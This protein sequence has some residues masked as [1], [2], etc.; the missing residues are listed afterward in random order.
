MAERTRRLS[1]RAKHDQVVYVTI[2]L[3]AML[4]TDN[5][6]MILIEGVDRAGKSTLTKALKNT[7][8]WDSLTLTHRAGNQFDRYLRAYSF[9]QQCVVE[10]GHLS[11]LIYSQILR[12]ASP[13]SE[14]ELAE[15]ESW[16]Q[17]S[18]VVW[19]C[20]EWELCK[21]RYESDPLPPVI[22]P[23]QLRESWENYNE[24]FFK[25]TYPNLYV[26]HSDVWEEIDSCCQ[27]VSARAEE[28]GW[29]SSAS[30]HIEQ[31]ENQGE[32]NKK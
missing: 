31:T 7:L 9:A 24:Y 3:L 22:S 17:P 28:L 26:Y 20:P 19:A 10:R 12:G 23:E 4:L 16:V 14:L 32:A 1:G 11:E 21:L 27:W 6:Q 30:F 5:P 8:G 25:H 29:E 18:I 2:Y 13:F 15:L